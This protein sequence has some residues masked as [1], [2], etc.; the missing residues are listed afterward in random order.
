MKPFFNSVSI[1]QY[2]QS[3]QTRRQNLRTIGVLGAGLFLPVAA[4][5]ACTLVP[6]MTEGPYWVEEKLKRQDITTGTTRN[7]V[8]G[9]LPLTLAIQLQ[10]DNGQQCSIDPARNVVVDIWHCD[11]AG[12]YSD[13]S[14]NGQ[15]S[16]IG[17]D[18]LRGYQLTDDTGLVTFRT[19]YP[20]WYSGRTTHI[21]LRA[22]AYD[23]N[24]NT[25]YNF[26]SQLFFDDTITDQVYQRTLYA[27]R[28]IRNTRN[29]NDGI[30]RAS[31][32]S[33]M[34]SLTTLSDGSMRGDVTLGLGVLP[35][36]TALQGFAASLRK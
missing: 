15:S 4:R 27:S 17:Q 34:V 13:S 36:T 6:S 24:G 26:T 12:E 31:N 25:T 14:G 21:H 32:T 22:R 29:S 35:Q 1:D 2:L 30:Y 28:G 23:Q 3:V 8:L 19:I 7:S 18:F 20:G 5:A 11:A 16:T 9:G 10:D 33:P